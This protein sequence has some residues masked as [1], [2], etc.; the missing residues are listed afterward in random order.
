ML[1]VAQHDAA[2]VADAQAVHQHPAGRD[3]CRSP[4]CLSG[5]I[6]TTLPISV[7]RMFCG[8]MPMDLAS[9]GVLMQMLLLAVDGDEELRAG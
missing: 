4:P 1:A 7:I 9:T 8:G 5:V 2:H 6:S 3:G